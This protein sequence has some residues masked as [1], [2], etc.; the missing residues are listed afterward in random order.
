MQDRSEGNE[1]ESLNELD[2]SALDDTLVESPLNEDEEAL[3]RW[4]NEVYKRLSAQVTQVWVKPE[5][6]SSLFQGVIPL[7]VDLQG[8]L[9]RAW[10]HLPSGDPALDQSALLAVKSIIR[11]QLPESSDM[12][13]YYQNLEFRYSGG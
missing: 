5:D 7:N 13:R 8:Y 4:Y 1:D 3:R 11:Y 6:S 2:D 9:N 12:A 10:I